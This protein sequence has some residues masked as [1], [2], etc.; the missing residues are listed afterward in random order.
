MNTPHGRSEVEAR[1]GCP[2]G[3]SGELHPLWE[4][5]NLIV[6]PPPV[7]WQL[8]YQGDGEIIPTRG[9]RI[10]HL[11]EDSFRE[12]LADVWS[13]A[14]RHVKAAEGYDKST[15]HYDKATRA[16]LHARRLDLHGGGF[17]FRPVTGGHGLSMHAYGI[18]IDWDP[19]HN[20]RGKAQRPTLPEWWYEIWRRHGW[21]D[22]RHF[23]TPDPMHVQF[24]SGV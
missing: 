9:I 8:Y 17:N 7:P 20:P 3:P 5:E 21:I 19:E 14:R 24:A 10:H 6:A 12:V 22:G 1:F 2:A 15:A 18:A 11:L 4:Q 13:S 16:W 23:P